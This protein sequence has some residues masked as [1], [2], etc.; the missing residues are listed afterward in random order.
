MDKFGS[1]SIHERF[2]VRKVNLGAV[3]AVK[4]REAAKH[5][6]NEAPPELFLVGKF[7]PHEI[8]V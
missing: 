8:P 2:T 7:A 5:W 3:I 6:E 4:H 1:R